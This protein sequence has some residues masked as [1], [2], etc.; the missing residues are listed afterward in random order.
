MIALVK[1]FIFE[2]RGD[3]VVVDVNGVG[4]EIIMYPRAVAKLPGQGKSILLYTHLQVLENEFKLYGFLEREELYLFKR[5][6]SVSGMGAKGA[7]NILDFIDPRGFYQAIVSQDEKLLV[8]IPGIGKKSASRLIF[9]L[10]DKIGQEQLAVLPGR[11]DS[12]VNDLLEAFEA[13]GYGRSEIFPLVMEMQSRG[14]LG[15]NV[16]ENL[17][18]ILKVRALQMKG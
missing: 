15:A 11:D 12:S 7:L 9:E 1:G 13:L 4:Y 5:L 16:E 8:K 6:L 3:M 14:E 17:K 10:K 18:K 2:Q